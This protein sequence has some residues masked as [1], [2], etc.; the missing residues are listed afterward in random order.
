MIITFYDT[1]P[2]NIPKLFPI[3]M[4]LRRNT[5]INDTGNCVIFVIINRGREWKIHQFEQGSLQILEELKICKMKAV[6]SAQ[7]WH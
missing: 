7:V 4:Q 3:K 1:F 5:V 2:V 6:V